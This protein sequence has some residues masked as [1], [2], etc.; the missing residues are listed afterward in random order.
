[1]DEM[2]SRIAAS[3]EEKLT[4]KLQERIEEMKKTLTEQMDNR[5]TTL[6]ETI[7]NNITTIIQ[8]SLEDLTTSM[9][10]TLTNPY[11]TH[12]ILPQAVQAK[13]GLKQT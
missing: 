7:E 5:M 6:S 3:I 12:R 8:K 9:Q 13:H 1:M 2:E 11:L 4:S 10:N